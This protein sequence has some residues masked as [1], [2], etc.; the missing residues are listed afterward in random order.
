MSE[1]LKIE[2]E[3]D[4]KTGE[5]RIKGLGQ[6][7]ADAGKKGKAGFTSA[8]AGAESLTSKLGPAGSMLLKLGGAIG[9]LMILR[10]GFNELNSAV[11]ECITE[12]NAA[13]AAESDLQATLRATGG[14][15]GY[16]L[17]QLKKMASGMQAATTV[18]DD[19]IIGGMSILAT[20]KQVRGEGFERASQAALDMSQ[21]MKQDLKSSMVQIGKAVN[22]PIEGVSALT[23]VGVTFNEQQKE[24]IKTLQ[25]SGDMVGAQN[26]ILKELETQFGG[27]AK[28]ARETFGGAVKASQNAL[29]D[30]KEEIG[31]VITKNQ[32]FVSLIHLAEKQFMS[33]GQQ[34]QNNRE[35]LM[36]LA[37][38][39]V[40]KVVDGLM[41][42]LETMRFFHNGWLGIKLVGSAAVA[43]IAIGIETL[44]KGLRVMMFGWDALFDALV[45]LGVM[46][47]NPFDS[48]VKGLEQFSA[49]SMD[50][51]KSVWADIEK[52]NAGYDSAKKAIG[53]W[54]SAIEKIPVTQAKAAESVIKSVQAA[55]DE[56]VVSQKDMADAEKER[57]AAVVRD[58]KLE[59]KARI[60]AGKKALNI[61]IDRKRA[62]DDVAK[63]AEKLRREAAA[64]EKKLAGDRANAYRTMYG[65]LKGKARD[66]YTYQ[67]QLLKNE[68]DEYERLVGDKTLADQWYTAK[69]KALLQEQDLAFGNFVDGVRIGHQRM[70]DSA[71][72]FAM[73]GEDTFKAFTSS[74]SSSFATFI[75][76][77]KDDFLSLP[78][79]VDSVMNSV[80]D[81]MTKA[82]AEIVKQWVIAKAAKLVGDIFFHEGAWNIKEDE[83]PAILQRGETVL[84]KDRAA[85]FRQMFGSEGGFDSFANSYNTAAGG[86]MSPAQRAGFASFGKSMTVNAAA[87]GAQVIN[88]PSLFGA[89]LNALGMS[90]PT[91]GLGGLTVGLER[92]LGFNIGLDMPTKMGTQLAAA[93]GGIIGGPIGAA[94][95]HFG[96]TLGLDAIADAI[97][98]RSFEGI[99]DALEAK[100]GWFGGRKEFSDFTESSGMA[101]WGAGAPGRG[102]VGDDPMASYG[103]GRGMPGDDPSAGDYS[104]VSDDE[105][106]FG[107]AD[108]KVGGIARGPLSGYRPRLHGTEAV[109]P[110]P[111]GRSIPVEMKGGGDDLVAEIRQLRAELKA[112]NYAIAKNTGISARILD[113]WDGDG[114]PAERVV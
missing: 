95:A 51:T 97:N 86:S 52:T 16:N 47:V 36:S 65:D 71:Y 70:Q 112:A 98:A 17:E 87:I 34:I 14:A 103:Y 104:G 39:G 83:Q 107:A 60:D 18:G 21:I 59:E 8:A 11:S 84:N 74:A 68:R 58:L 31:F 20:F 46:K 22:D 26:I 15:A 27:A 35:Y 88:D 32:F 85:E 102:M 79:L 6:E 82:A 62:E 111:N 61:L 53:D 33:W 90:M 78:A 40:L 94:I 54:R 105:G 75:N 92:A 25:E 76:P 106:G 43:A 73:M 42:A 101:G 99:R 28:A 13:E 38:E 4:S 50:V 24:Q 109:V 96:A 56:V 48:I 64:D 41:I 110:L 3:V 2:I 69:N 63:D 108:F 67:D 93:L 77:L 44:A 19:L 55:A 91:A 12:A 100:Y 45:K 81:S 29:G 9:G 37:K 10:K 49:S 23:R 1:K 66:Y 89:G 7:M 30:M 113:R 57:V 5:A 72:T 80:V 114:L